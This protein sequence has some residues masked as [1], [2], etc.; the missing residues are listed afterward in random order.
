MRGSLA[1]SATPQSRV[2]KARV[3]QRD[4]G[5]GLRDDKQTAHASV[6]ERN[7]V[8]RLRFVLVGTTN[9]APPNEKG[10]DQRKQI[11]AKLEY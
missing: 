9:A 8:T 10:G 6:G 5:M 7:I 1:R 4:L 3:G 11:P 2:D